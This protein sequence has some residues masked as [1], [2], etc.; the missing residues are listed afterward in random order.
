MPRA[1]VGVVEFIA[2]DLAGP[3]LGHQ[4]DSP[5]STIVRSDWRPSDV[6]VLPGVGPRG[7]EVLAVA[8][9]YGNM[10]RLYGYVESRDDSL[11]Y[12]PCG[13][14]GCKTRRSAQPLEGAKGNL[15]RPSGL[16]TA[17]FGVDSDGCPWALLLI[18]ETGAMCVSVFRVRPM[19]MSLEG[20]HDQQPHTLV[21]DHLS[22][23]GM[24]LLGSG[25]HVPHRGQWGWLGVAF[26]CNGDVLVTD[27]D[28]DVLLVV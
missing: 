25:L 10:V 2:A 28:N 1:L 23:L 15:E 9:Y 6:A 4:Q 14:V 5:L 13:S 22:D 17:S 19:K 18:A 24:E 20:D 12:T 21:A 3:S 11:G 27:C 16:A 8:N 26:A 7:F